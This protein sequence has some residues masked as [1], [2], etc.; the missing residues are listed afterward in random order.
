MVAHRGFEP[1][2]SALRGPRPRPLDECALTTKIIPYSIRARKRDSRAEGGHLGTAA[3]KTR[4]HKDA[5]R[6]DGCTYA[7][8][9]RFV[10]SCLVARSPRY[11]CHKDAKAQRRTK[12]RWVHQCFFVPLRLRAWWRDPT[13]PLPQRRKGT[14]THKGQMAGIDTD[15]L[16]SFFVPL[17]VFVPCGERSQCSAT[18]GLG[19][20]H[21]KRGQ[22][23]AFSF[24]APT[25]RNRNPTADMPA[26]HSGRP[27][28]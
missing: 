17:R 10:S 15:R 16:R 24:L 26:V 28:A 20:G 1:L 13:V 22:E 27:T 4:R 25:Q 2:I 3:T 7:S 23:Q 19:L 5:P 8:S 9:C 6:G 12:G 18:V 14:K 21:E 11:P